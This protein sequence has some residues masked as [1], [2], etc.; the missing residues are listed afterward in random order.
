MGGFHTGRNAIGPR[1]DVVYMTNRGELR[2][3]SAGVL[4]TPA[5]NLST[6]RK[7]AHIA[8]FVVC[9]HKHDRNF[10]STYVR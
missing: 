2:L 8:H 1:R 5:P 7:T 9:E 4:E 6:M 10:T 3:L